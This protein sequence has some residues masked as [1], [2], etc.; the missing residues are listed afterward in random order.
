MSIW[1]VL[2]GKKRLIALVY[3][4]VLMP[5]LA[6]I[7]PDGFTTPFSIAFYKITTIFG[8]FLS[9]IGLGH[10]AVKKYVTKNGEVVEEPVEIIEEQ[11]NAEDKKDS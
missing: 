10:A 3:W 7:W 6:V 5:S 11:V 8:M 1:Q 9:A 2:D 4:S